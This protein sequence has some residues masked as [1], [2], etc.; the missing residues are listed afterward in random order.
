M[1]AFDLARPVAARVDACGLICPLPILKAKKALSSLESGQILAVQTT[2]RNAIRDFQAF[3]IQSRNV[4]LE[5]VQTATVC[6]HY[7]ARR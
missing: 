2:D 3:C 6:T 4:L 1:S 5:Q 7:I